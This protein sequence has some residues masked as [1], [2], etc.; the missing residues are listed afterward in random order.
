[1]IIP[2]KFNVGHTFWVPRCNPEY[3]TEEMHFEGETWLREVVK[4]VGYAK[5]KKIIKIVASTYAGDKVHI[6][7]YVLNTD[8][9]INSMSQVYSQDNINDYTE[10]EALNIAKEYE[11]QEKE[12]YGN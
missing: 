5:Q 1:M 3:S 6:Q 8:D 7:Y 11:E 10:E 12:Y 9:E 2:T 4:Y